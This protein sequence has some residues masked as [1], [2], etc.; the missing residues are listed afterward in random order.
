MALLGGIARQ[1]GGVVPISA[2]HGWVRRGANSYSI[3][4]GQT[5][6]EDQQRCSP[7][8]IFGTRGKGMT[9][10][11]VRLEEETQHAQPRL[12]SSPLEPAC[13]PKSL[14]LCLSIL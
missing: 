10:G 8:S 5:A 11:M 9:V 13:L 4:W 3:A 1:E 7:L 12:L 14:I 6:R 2:V